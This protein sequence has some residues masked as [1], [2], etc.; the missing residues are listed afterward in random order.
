MEHF[1]FRSNSP[2]SDL[3]ETH[4]DD[5]FTAE[6]DDVHNQSNTETHGHI[7]ASGAV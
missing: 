6:E 4:V 2:S 3:W 7:C 1:K 5:L